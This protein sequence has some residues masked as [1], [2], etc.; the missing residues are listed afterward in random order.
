MNNQILDL[1]FYSQI[2]EILENARKKTYT[3]INFAMV[4]AYWEI[5][6]SIVKVQEGNKTAKYGK[7]VLEE[8]SK[9]LTKDYGKGFTSTNLRYM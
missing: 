9:A 1:N 6:R 5:G 7:Q 8:L 2:K 3:A 4:E